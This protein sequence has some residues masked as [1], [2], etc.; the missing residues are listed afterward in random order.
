MW[1]Y[2]CVFDTQGSIWSSK[3]EAAEI[4]FS[5][6]KA[7]LKHLFWHWFEAAT[8]KELWH[9]L[10]QN[11]SGLLVLRRSVDFP[12]MQM[13]THA[14]FTLT[15]LTWWFSALWCIWKNVH[16]TCW[17]M[18]SRLH[19]WGFVTCACVWTWLAC[20][21]I[22]KSP[23]AWLIGQ[24]SSKSLVARRFACI[25]LLHYAANIIL[26]VASRSVDIVDNAAKV[27]D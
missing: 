12:H 19:I 8:P 6:C 26:A 10:Y 27:H 21:K 23:W 13:L 1:F 4:I 7:D 20:M 24:L 2:S 22:H 16:V 9:C 3:F 5:F 11:S 15:S 14:G 17:L 25:L 18:L